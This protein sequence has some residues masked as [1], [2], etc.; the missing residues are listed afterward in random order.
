MQVAATA[1]SSLAVKG[2]TR[3]EFCRAAGWCPRAE[4]SRCHLLE[5][6]VCD[7]VPPLHPHEGFLPPRAD[8]SPHGGK[9]NHSSLHLSSFAVIR[10]EG[11]KFSSSCLVPA[12]A[13]QLGNSDSRPR[14]SLAQGRQHLCLNDFYKSELNEV[15]KP[16]IRYKPEAYDKN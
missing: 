12:L 15:V 8:A 4:R 6:R 11:G 13:T 7:N 5:S 14:C 2:R 9:Q 16:Q 1:A 10:T 3:A